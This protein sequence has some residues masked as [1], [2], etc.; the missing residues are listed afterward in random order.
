MAVAMKITADAFN[1]MPYDSGMLLNRF[2]VNNPTTPADADI[3]CTTTGDITINCNLET[4]D[5]SEDVNNLHGEFME[6]QQP[7]GWTVEMS[8]TALEMTPEVL[9]TAFG[10]ADV[11]GNKVSPR[12]TFYLR[13]FRD[14]WW[15]GKTLGGGLVVAHIMNAIST[16]GVQFTTTKNGKGTMGVT[17]KGFASLQA[18]DVVPVEFYV[19]EAETPSISLSARTVKMRVGDSAYR[20]DVTTVP[21]DATVTWEVGD[22]DVCTI[23]E[24]WYGCNITPVGAG[25]SSVTAKMTVD[26][27]T[28]TATCLVDVSTNTGA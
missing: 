9:R 3:V 27:E 11:D 5:L 26:G 17:L 13:D 14:L 6:F 18:Q 23:E 25:R 19:L 20:L 12:N 8:F 16:G 28:Y 22:T 7:N 15:V 1:N 24:K 10:A 21:D 2:N 4:I